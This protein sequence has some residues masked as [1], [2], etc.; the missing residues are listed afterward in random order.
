MDSESRWMGILLFLSDFIGHVIGV[1]DQFGSF[2]HDYKNVLISFLRHCF[3]SP[4]L[5]IPNWLKI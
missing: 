2:H 1:T 4:I 3:P 5:I